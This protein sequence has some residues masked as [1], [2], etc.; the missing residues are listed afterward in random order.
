MNLAPPPALVACDID[1]T[2]LRTGNP[3]SPGVRAAA[4]AVRAAGHHIVLATGRSLVGALSVAQELELD[5]DI[6]IVASNGAVTAHVTGSGFEVI[7]QHDLEAETAIRAALAASPG[8]RIAAE[9]VGVGYRVNIPFPDS[10]V[11]GT[12]NSVTGLEELWA[13]PTPRL[14]L[15]GPSAYRA[16]PALRALGITAIPTRTDWVDVTPPGLSKAT[17]LEKVRTELGVEDDATVAVGDSENDLEMLLWASTGFAMGHAPVPVRAAADH[18]TGTLDDDGAATVL[19][20][21]LA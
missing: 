17:A 9:V 3:A 21:L 5:D 19:R 15:Y 4:T 6:W 18:V 14:A 13:E 20:S 10:E 16:V 12:Q 8:L 7:T 2:L 11:N 1:G